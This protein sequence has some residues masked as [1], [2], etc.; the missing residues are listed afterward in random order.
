LS[1]IFGGILSGESI[2][3]LRGDRGVIT[4]FRFQGS[5]RGTAREGGRRRWAGPVGVAP[6]VWLGGRR[7]W[8]G[9]VGVAPHVWLGGRAGPGRAV[10]GSQ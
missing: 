2:L 4:R 6:H 10:N 3:I 5:K 9:P 8:A 1:E 7:R